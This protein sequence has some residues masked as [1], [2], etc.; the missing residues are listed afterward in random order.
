[1]NGWG[2][3]TPAG[4][5]LRGQAAAL[6]LHLAAC[7]AASTGRA[8][9]GIVPSHGGLFPHAGEREDLARSTAVH[10]EAN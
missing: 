2:A 8:L 1:M 6:E 10:R 4:D 7:K 5:L 3:L 9:F